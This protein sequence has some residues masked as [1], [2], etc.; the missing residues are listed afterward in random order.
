M[1][2]L[3]DSVE[4]EVLDRSIKMTYHLLQETCVIN[5]ISVLIHKDDERI[6]MLISCVPWQI[7]PRQADRGGP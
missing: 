7:M 3:L 6:D 1:E 5:D 2:F 4:D